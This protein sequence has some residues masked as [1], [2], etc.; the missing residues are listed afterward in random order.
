MVDTWAD[1]GPGGGI[2]PGRST[3]YLMALKNETNTAEEAEFWALEGTPVSPAPDGDG[4]HRV[5]IVNTTGV[6]RGV[7]EAKL[8]VVDHPHGLAVGPDIQGNIRPVSGLVPPLSAT[9]GDGVDVMSLVRDKDDVFWRGRGGDPGPGATAQPH[10]EIILEFPKPRGAREALLI[11]NAA[12]T[13][14]PP[15]FAAAALERAKAMAESGQVDAAY[16]DWE[17]AK[18]KVGLLT[19][20][21]RQTGQVIFAG[22]PL[23]AGDKAYRMT[24]DDVCSDK[25][26][27][28]L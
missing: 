11:V 5:A 24:L 27:L 10:D 16:K 1:S 2:K 18:L 12:N 15:R 3:G 14:W 26:T 6:P 28:K 17:Y 19:G 23:A 21:G 13:D 8:V 4:K 25:V 22:G 9:D 20:F 7:D